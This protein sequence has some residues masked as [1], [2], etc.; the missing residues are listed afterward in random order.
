M[1]DAEVWKILLPFLGS[2]APL[3]AFSWL[4]YRLLE[5]TF[6]SQAKREEAFE[7]AAR[8]RSVEQAARDAALINFM[9]MLEERTRPLAWNGDITPIPYQTPQQQAAPYHL[10]RE[11]TGV[12]H[13]V[14]RAQPKP[15]RRPAPDTPDDEGEE[16]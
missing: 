15:R 1:S 9:G 14:P 6:R 8:D 3:G 10:R 12:M 5:R 4:V 7:Q 2:A 11:T 13:A 16:T